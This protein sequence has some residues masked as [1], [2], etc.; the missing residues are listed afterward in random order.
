MRKEEKAELAKLVKQTIAAGYNEASVVNKLK[1]YGYK[2]ST[3][4]TYYK[5]F[6]VRD[7]VELNLNR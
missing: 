4:R 1:R 6:V 5:A 2:D 7:I 3:I